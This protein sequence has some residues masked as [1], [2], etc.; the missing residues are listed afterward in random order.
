MVLVK[1]P[2]WVIP[3]GAGAASVTVQMSC[4]VTQMHIYMKLFFLSSQYIYILKSKTA[5][6]DS[7]RKKNPG[8]STV[9]TDV[10]VSS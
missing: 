8:S 3:A 7:G 5:G 4:S 9:M 6:V 10:I 2:L 1:P